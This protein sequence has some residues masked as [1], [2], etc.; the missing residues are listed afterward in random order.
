LWDDGRFDGKCTTTYNANKLTL[1]GPEKAEWKRFKNSVTS[2]QHNISLSAYVATL[3]V[4]GKSGLSA[5]VGW[6][7]TTY[8]ARSTYH[9]CGNDEKPAFASRVFAGH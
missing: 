1:Q 6:E 2:F 7:Y 8:G 4:R 9:L 3:A 5:R